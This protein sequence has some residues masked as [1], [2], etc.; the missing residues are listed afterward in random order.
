MKSEDD[1]TSYGEELREYAKDAS[2][3]LK[4]MQDSW[5]KLADIIYEMK[6]L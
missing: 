1:I 4:E 3:V 6:Q 5:D 2:E